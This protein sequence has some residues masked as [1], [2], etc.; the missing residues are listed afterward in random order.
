MRSLAPHVRRGHRVRAPGP[1]RSPLPC[2]AAAGRPLVLVNREADGVTSVVLDQRCIVALA[3]EHL[4]GL[5]HESIA[6]VRGPHGSW[7]SHRRERALDRLDA[8]IIVLRSVEPT[9]DGGHVLLAEVERRG[10]VTA[11]VV[12]NDVM[13][14]GLIAADA[15]GVDVP[16]RLSVIGADGVPFGAMTT[17]CSPPSP[18]TSTSSATSLSWTSSRIRGDHALP[19]EQTVAPTLVVRVDRRTRLSSLDSPDPTAPHGPSATGTVGRRPNRDRRDQG[20]LR[21]R[22][23]GST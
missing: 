6:L 19:D 13:A 10:Q 12:F 8:P 20:S 11:V 18:S 15:A 5:G 3:L 7:S 22:S 1:R 4:R 14:L 17:P 9:F 2:D 21:S 23:W 16:G